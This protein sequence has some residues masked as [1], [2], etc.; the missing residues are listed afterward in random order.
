MDLYTQAKL[1]FIRDV[2]RIAEGRKVSWKVVGTFVKELITKKKGSL[3]PLEFLLSDIKYSYGVS[4]LV[5]DLYIMRFITDYKKDG[6]I[7]TAKV[8]VLVDLVKTEFDC[9]FYENYYTCFLASEHIVLTANGLSLLR[10]NL[11]NDPLNMNKG[12]ALAEKLADLQAKRELLVMYYFNFPEMEHVRFRNAAIM[13]RHIRTLSDGYN[14][15]GKDILHIHDP[16]DS[17]P[18]C[19][20]NKRYHT[21]LQCSHQFCVDC[22]SKHIGTVGDS[23]GKCPLCR[24]LLML[25]L[26]DV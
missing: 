11:F 4:E 7:T 3:E 6:G 26:V 25:K 14:V 8:S 19:F 21:T 10:F 15:Y 22:L 24:K 20:E 23:H 18:I 2:D 5:N 13:K 1:Q 16:T 12:I 17:C 9:V